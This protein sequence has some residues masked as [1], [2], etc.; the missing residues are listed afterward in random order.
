MGYTL[1][2]D[3]GSN[4]I[5]WAI[6]DEEAEKI[7]NCGVRI[8]HEGVNVDSKSG[9]ESPKNAE[10][11]EFRQTRRQHRRRKLRINMMERLL[12]KL[13][14]MPDFN[15]RKKW[16][17]LNP[18]FLR[19]YGLDNELTKEEF[20]RILFQFA[21]RRGFK[22]SRNGD[23]K[24][25]K[26]DE[27]D[28]NTGKIGL[29]DN[30]KILDNG[31]RTL[32]E[33]FY[34]I[35]HLENE[36]FILKERIRNRVIK[37]QNYIDE[38]EKLW[39]KQKEFKPDFYTDELKSK[40]GDPKKGILFFQRELL[41]QKKTIGK[42]M[43]EK[44][45]QRCPISR[46]EFE[47]F[48]TWQVLNNLRLNGEP[49]SF[50]LKCDFYNYIANKSADTKISDL[51]KK[52]KLGDAKFNY[53]DDTKFSAH[54]TDYRFNQII[55]LFPKVRL[56][57]FD[58]EKLKYEM[59][60]VLYFAKNNEWLHNHAQNRWDFSQE[61]AD[62]LCKINLKDG[63]SKLSLKAIKNILP[64]LRNGRLY[65]D[66]V[67]LAGV[68]N[69]LADLK[70]E[71]APEEI[72]KIYN[73]ID[74]ELNTNLPKGELSN[75]IKEYLKVNYNISEKQ[76]KKLYHPSE[77][78][79][80]KSKNDLLGMPDN[81]RNPIVQKG[82]YE[83]RKVVNALQNE[84]GGF[85]RINIELA[86]ELK[87]NQKQ[88]LET[89][90]NNRKREKINKEAEE[91]LEQVGLAISRENIQKYVLYKEMEAKNQNTIC[92]YSHKPISINQVFS[93]SNI[94]EV[95]HMIPYS[96]S[97]DDSYSNKVLCFR[98]ENHQKGDRTP[99]EYFSA[100]K[101]RWQLMKDT[102]FKILPYNKAKKFANENPMTFQD[103]AS[104]Q[105]NDTRYFSKYATLYLQQICDNV[106]TYSGG[107]TA[108][109]RHNWGLNSI[110]NKQEDEKNRDDHRHH[111]IDALV[112]ANTNKK[113]LFRISNPEKF[114]YVKKDI[115]PPPWESFRKDAEKAIS[116]V[117]VSFE[118]RIQITTKIVTKKKKK[119]KVY[120]TEGYA[121]RGK[122][123][124]ET[125]YG[126]RLSPVDNRYYYNV[127][128]PIDSIENSA[129]INR[130]ADPTI[131]KIVL[132][133]LQELGVKIN[134]K[135]YDVPK[136]AFTRFNPET[137]L[138]E[139]TLFLNNKRGKPVPINKIRLTNNLGNTS[140]LH[141]GINQYVDPD[142]NYIVAIYEDEDG[143][144]SELIL[145]FWEAVNRQRNKI[146]IVPPYL[147]GAK[148]KFTMKR[149]EMFLVGMD[150]DSSEIYNLSKK[151]IFD[152]LYRVQKLS[153]KYYVFRKHNA[154]TIN[155]D[156]EMIMI[157]SLGALKKAKL[158]KVRIDVLGNLI[159]LKE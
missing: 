19:W 143:N 124:A 91:Y 69:A 101:E 155:F 48:R 90:Y 60:D 139:T 105:L 96:R 17:R 66:A 58:I 61:Q 92:P 144:Y 109:L 100:D 131:K 157:R 77:I 126:K 150:I 115:F 151:Q 98:E 7:I 65:Y 62:L 78:E 128:V 56:K 22:S 59:W 9:K 40:I 83:L 84:Y 142:N 45:K 80:E 23:A 117:L 71:L 12:I 6:I 38:F 54:Y 31:F 18:Y 36:P 97:L 136:D 112:V 133:R 29:N 93:D 64:H 35:S 89:L 2:L 107:I 73:Y 104:K 15:N 146:E 27:T 120:K 72:D 25:T 63:Y 47:E 75:R 3:V 129:K 108:K 24:E 138:K 95:D 113:F 152:N 125:V 70:K 99:F 134:N 118:N 55:K 149:N 88:R 103:F 49:I 154:A 32:G 46:V 14:M 130:I 116:D 137:G 53:D 41:S 8:F 135:K 30:Q 11:R 33:Y 119:G 51:H 68:D 21:K 106:N 50:E 85:T 94:I 102:A 34:T 148:L 10:R 13:E 158:L 141:E 16:L 20:G 44:N 132:N 159:I 79:I 42:C 153:S 127:R 67:I 121:V 87:Q 86:R 123:H 111:I 147:D 1:G 43:F 156:S 82:L 57:F 52:F 122:L 145:T 39:E 76:L 114:K 74:I 5:G 26:I 110:L 81:L 140:Q 4:S 37:R 28:K